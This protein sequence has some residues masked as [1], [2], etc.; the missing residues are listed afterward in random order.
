MQVSDLTGRCPSHCDRNWHLPVGQ[1]QMPNSAR[2]VRL[3]RRSLTGIASTSLIKELW[4]F[5]RNM[6]PALQPL[7]L[8]WE[9]GAI[10]LLRVAAER[11]KRA[12]PPLFPIQRDEAS[13]VG[14]SMAPGRRETG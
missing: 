1:H 7:A 4:A 14:R 13:I 6:M 12:S 11:E 5:I 3:Y 10:I 8:A 9:P 2:R